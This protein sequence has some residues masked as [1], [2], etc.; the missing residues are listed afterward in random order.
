MMLAARLSRVPLTTLVGS[1]G[2]K[3]QTVKPV[4]NAYN[5]TRCQMYSTR[6]SRFVRRQETKGAQK[7]GILKGKLM[8]PAGEGGK[9]TVI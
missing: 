3:T 6:A 2:C 4:L 9:Y 5:L 8:A 1:Y 7:T